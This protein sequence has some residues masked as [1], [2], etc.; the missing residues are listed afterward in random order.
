MTEAFQKEREQWQ[1]EV[2]DLH[3]E[4]ERWRHGAIFAEGTFVCPNE[5]EVKSLR[6]QLEEQTENLGAL[7]DYWQKKA[8]DLTKEDQEAMRMIRTGILVPS[9]IQA[10]KDGNVPPI[11]EALIKVLGVFDRLVPR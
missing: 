2:L 1:K 9:L 3:R 10:L 6:K 5:A 8:V 11:E 7:V 4:L